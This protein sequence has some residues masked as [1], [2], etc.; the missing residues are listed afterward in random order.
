[1]RLF[2]ETRM[3]LSPLQSSRGL[4]LTLLVG[5]SFAFAVP[6]I[7]AEDIM[8]EWDFN[9]AEIVDNTIV[10][11]LAEGEAGDLVLQSSRRNCRVQR[12]A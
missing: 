10:V 5:L 1:M 9:K 4:A 12:E 3:M 11:P 6:R 7:L 8:G 2:Y